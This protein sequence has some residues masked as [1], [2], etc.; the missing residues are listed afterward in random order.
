MNISKNKLKKALEQSDKSSQKTNQI[1]DLWQ[2]L[3]LKKIDTKAKP[4]NPNDKA[5]KYGK[6]NSKFGLCLIAL[7][8]DGISNLIFPSSISSGKAELQ[9][10]WPDHTLVEDQDR[11]TKI[12]E[13][14]FNP[15]ANHT[16]KIS[17]YHKGTDF[18]SNIWRVL[19]KI[20]KGSLLSY[21]DIAVK[22]QKP[23]ASRAVGNAV[24]ANA[25]AWLIPCHR[26]VRDNGELGGFRWGTKVKS[27]MLEYEL[28]E[29]F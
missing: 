23:N 8:Y 2:H 19:Q 11:A 22:I 14:T 12:A 7:Y 27:A 20:P 18:Q 6:Y 13:K 3:E 29:S 1:N 25:I 26:V 4:N 21:K 28:G 15:D 5:L 24:G 17:L 9:N 10:H 16:K